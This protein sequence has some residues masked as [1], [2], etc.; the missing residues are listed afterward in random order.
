MKLFIDWMSRS[1]ASTNDRRAGDETPWAS[2]LLRGR[3]PATA[4]G[5]LR[6]T[7]MTKGIAFM[8]G[9]AEGGIGSDS[10]AARSSPIRRGEATAGRTEGP[11]LRDLASFFA[12]VRAGLGFV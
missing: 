4:R 7:S 12:G 8:V 9:L 3:S 6:A 10:T 11:E 1:A 2:G 5:P